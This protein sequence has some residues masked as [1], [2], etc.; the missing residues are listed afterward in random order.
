MEMLDRGVDAEA[1]CDDR[2]S[3]ERGALRPIPIPVVSS[4]VQVLALR[5]GRVPQST[6]NSTR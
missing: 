3:V 2:N 1:S 6:T 5:R 4:L